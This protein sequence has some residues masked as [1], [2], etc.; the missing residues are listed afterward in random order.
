MSKTFHGKGIKKTRFA[1]HLVQL[2]RR[3]VLI[4]HPPVATGTPC[5]RLSLAPARSA[6]SV[7]PSVGSRASV[8]LSLPVSVCGPWV[9]PCHLPVRTTVRAC[10]YAA[11]CCLLLLLEI[12]TTALAREEDRGALLI[13][14][15]GGVHRRSIRSISPRAR[16]SRYRA[17]RLAGSGRPGG[18]PGG[19]AVACGIGWFAQRDGQARPATRMKEGGVRTHTRRRRVRLCRR[20]RRL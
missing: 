4:R 16:R 8:P 12:A 9:P 2:V 14:W 19:T 7:P 3:R 11:A 6:A 17:S 13:H 1:I 18:T 5:S 20:R 10:C 15:I